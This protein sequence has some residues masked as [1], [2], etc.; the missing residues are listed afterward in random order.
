MTDIL[1]N[2]LLLVDGSSYL[3]R[4]FHVFNLTNA[5]GM[6]T[7]AIYGVINMLKSTIKLVNPSNVVVVFDAKGKTFRDDLFSQYKSTRP[8]M[9]DDLRQQIEPLHKLIQ[10]LGY[11]LVSIEGVEADDVIGTLA[12]QAKNKQQNVL[13]ATGDKDMAQLVCEQINLVNTMQNTVLGID[14]VIAKYGVKPSQII[15]FLALQGDSSDCIPGVKGVGEKTAQA[16]INNFDSLENLYQ[17]IENNEENLNTD[18]IPRIKSTLKNLKEHKDMAFL[19]QQLATIKLD[20]E[21]NLTTEETKLLPPNLAEIRK[22]YTDLDFKNWLKDLDK[23]ASENTPITQNNTEKTTNNIFDSAKLSHKNY[24]IISDRQGLKLLIEKIQQQKYFSLVA[25]NTETNYM[26][27][28][29]SALTIGL[30]DGESFYIPLKSTELNTGLNFDEPEDFT[31]TEILSELKVVFSDEKILKVGHNL[32]L[33]LH[34]LENY[35]IKIKGLYF[36]NMLASYVLDSQQKH[37]LEGICK[38]YFQHELAD[39]KTFLGKGKTKLNLTQIEPQDGLIYFAEKAQINYELAKYLS[40]KLTDNQSINELFWGKEMPLLSVLQQME[41]YGVE[42]DIKKLSLQN[43]KLKQKLQAIEQ[44]VYLLAGEEFNLNSTLQLQQILF[45][46]LG[47]PI[48]KKTPKNAPS[49]NEEVLQELSLSFEIADYILQY[50]SL[51]K[52]INTYTDK[53]PQEVYAKTG[54]I[55]ATFNQ[56]GTITGRLSSNSPNLQNIPARNEEGRLIRQSFVARKGYKIMAADYSQIE[57]RIMAHLSNDEGLIN[58]FMQG[59]DIHKATAAEIFQIPL[60][61]VSSEQRRGAKAINFGL[62]YGMSSFGLAKELG[63]N[64]AD[65]KGYIDLYFSRYPEVKRFM[66]AIKASAYDQGFVE[67]ILQRRLYIPEIR[68]KGM[69][70]KAAERLAINAPM[71]GSAADIIKVAMLNL[72][73]IL[74]KN[75]I[76]LIMQVHDELVFEVLESKVDYYKD[77]IQQKMEQAIELKV[78]LV[79]DIG[80][81]D[82]WDEAH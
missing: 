14:E 66:G 44:Q 64:M 6:P 51:A 24:K 29:L 45:D 52:L 82:N 37:S 79:V 41:R 49:T 18:L 11:K 59:K 19:S 58:A 69:R 17:Q 56:V 53:L 81:G 28:Q 71:Q 8:P 70:A 13:I 50:R 46:K 16:L 30:A 26:Q 15:D 42:L 67:T 31:T 12:V 10:A 27:T 75:E 38:H 32:K 65:A 68:A 36:D 2:S 35:N 3:Y 5:K 63:I 73:P 7:G 48:L 74:A 22:I 77:I 62:I 39:L 61:Q 55:H 72:A 78:P 21:I 33:L 57:L 80:V 1:P 40:L 20:V 43:N 4:A 9:P 54:K 34:I 25:T 23:N 76:N 60:E 47:L